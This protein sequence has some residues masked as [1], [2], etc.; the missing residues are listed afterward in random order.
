M[1]DATTS[2]VCDAKGPGVLEHYRGVIWRS[3]I[4]TA[5]TADATED[6]TQ[7]VWL[8]TRL[9]KR[10][11]LGT[12]NRQSAKAAAVELNICQVHGSNN[13]FS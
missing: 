12:W 1:Y 6:R 3:W 8:W 11:R 5:W 2:S 4:K 10:C 13:F 7:A 9:R